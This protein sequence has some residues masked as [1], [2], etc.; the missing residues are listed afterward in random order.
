MRTAPTF[1]ELA[2]RPDEEIDVALG[3]ALIACD[4]YPEVDVTT[5]LGRLD[6]LAAP[7][8]VVGFAARSARGQADGL[9]HYMYD[10]C[11]F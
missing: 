1:E 11:G 3:A 5:L 6:E 9:A 4:V 10:T 8:V 7:L 2:A